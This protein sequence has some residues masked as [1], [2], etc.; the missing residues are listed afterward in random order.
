MNQI[1]AGIGLFVLAA[2]LFIVCPIAL[3]WALNTLF[4]LH[5]PLNFVTWLASA[6]LYY[7][8]SRPGNGISVNKKD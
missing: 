2:V 7:S 3:I 4:S 6:V 5:I 8:F 1:I